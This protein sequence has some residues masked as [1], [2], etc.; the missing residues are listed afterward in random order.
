MK[1]TL[2]KLKIA[3]HMS[4]ETTAFTADIFVDGKEAGYAKNDGHGGSTYYHPYEGKRDLI[5]KAEDFCLALPPIKYNST[6]LDDELVIPMDLE[7]FIDD[8]IEQELRNK[9]K[10]KFEKKMETRI[11]WGVAGGNSYTEVNF[12]R[13]LSSIPT[14]QLQ[15]QINIFKFKLKKGEV[16]L[17]TNLEKLGVKI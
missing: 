12:K 9:D 5:G 3:E 1:I 11:M 4:E 13:P 17:N 14:S 10:K 15:T 6:I 8:L 2:K 7:H 16:F